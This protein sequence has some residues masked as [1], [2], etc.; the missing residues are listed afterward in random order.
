MFAKIKNNQIDKWPIPSLVTDFPNTSFPIPLTE[1]DLPEN[2]VMV[3]P[4]TP[5]D[6]TSTQ[7]V[8]PGIP[9]KQDNK[10][11]QGWDIVEL[12]SQEL[13][14]AAEIVRL[15]NK[16]LRAVAYLQEADPLFFQEQRGEI[17]QGTW[18]DKVAEIKSRYPI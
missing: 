11:V 10:W 2:Y 7:R 18:L 17:P 5:P 9:V 6:V 15:K 16:N 1:E 8:V 13:Q 12:S 14:E 4:T 3:S